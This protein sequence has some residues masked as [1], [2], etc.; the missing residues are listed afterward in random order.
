MTAALR[1]YIRPLP[2][3]LYVVCD[4]DACDRAGW[5]LVDFAAACLDGGA[6]LLQVRAK[7]APSNWLLDCTARI[8]ERAEA[9]G[10]VEVIVN[11]RAD[12]ARLSGAAGV[13]VGQDDLSPRAVRR[14]VGDRFVV[15]L[16]THTS[17]QVEEALLEPLSH[18]A[19]GPVFGTTT[20]DTGYASLGLERVRSTA[21][22]TAPSGIPVVAIGGI[23]LDR[24][25]EVIA[26]GASAV[27]VIGDLI[28]PH[29]DRRVQAYL[30]RLLAI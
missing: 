12:V 6:R 25:A 16:S 27:A 24:A 4:A 28:G 2:S 7:R 21:A 22:A 8:V 29:P 3:P 9:F 11:D 19:I 14:V 18:I 20:K 1:D 17:E 30:Q 13:H 10:G 15:G 26:E 23:T 5:T